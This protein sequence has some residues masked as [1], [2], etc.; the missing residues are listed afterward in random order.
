M[1]AA[2]ARGQYIY[3]DVNGD[4][5]CTGAELLTSSTT[6]VDVY[7]DTNHD[8]NGTLKTCEANSSQPL[9]I[10]GYDILFTTGRDGPYGGVV[11]TGWSNAMSGFALLN[12][13]TVAGEDAG[14]GY[15][16]PLGTILPPGRYKLGTLQV[17]VTGHPTLSF[18]GESTNPSIPSPVTGFGST[19][20][21][22]WYANTITLGTDFS[23]NC[24][25]GGALDVQATTW[26]KIKLVY[27]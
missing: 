1:A 2:P 8:A 10:F 11:Y 26:G 12:P 16:A 13:F 18:R 9:D 19:C 24:G 21:A 22:T 20:E 6:T 7:L 27:R 15:T 3:M 25:T 23:D 14:V 17:A 4:A 5:L